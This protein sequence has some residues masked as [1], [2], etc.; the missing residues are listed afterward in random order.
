MKQEILKGFVIFIFVLIVGIFFFIVTREILSFVKVLKTGTVK[1]KRDIAFLIVL[2]CLSVIISKGRVFKFG[3]RRPLIKKKRDVALNLLRERI[4]GAQN[5]KEEA[6]AI[7]GFAYFLYKSEDPE[8]FDLAEE[9]FFKV[10]EQDANIEAKIHAC[11][12]LAHFFNKKDQAKTYF[13]NIIQQV[14]DIPRKEEILLFLVDLEKDNDKKEEYLQYLIN[15]DKDKEIQTVAWLEFSKM[16]LVEQ[17]NYGEYYNRFLVS[18][19]NQAKN[20]QI[21]VY[22]S[23]YLGV[24]KLEGDEEAA[25]KYLKIAVDQNI[26]NDIK[27]QAVSKLISLFRRQNRIMEIEQIQKYI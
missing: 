17:H 22:A 13:E 4:Q 26:V 9:N 2:I 23:Y 16:M 15:Q 14:E 7:L 12:A 18:W 21:K 5:K 6:V 24:V 25:E 8:L 1:E 10:A 19:A 20:E 11:F 27:E 3:R